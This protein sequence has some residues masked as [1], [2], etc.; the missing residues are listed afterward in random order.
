MAKNTK[1]TKKSPTTQGKPITD[2]FT[3]A[4]KPHPQP[5]KIRVSSSI[6]SQASSSEDIR[7]T[8]TSKTTGVLDNSKLAS[9]KYKPQIQSPRRHGRELLDGSESHSTKTSLSKT[10]FVS[11]SAISSR[12]LDSQ[13]HAGASAS[14][15]NKKALSDA[16]KMSDRRRN[17]RHSDSDTEMVN[18]TVHSTV[19]HSSI[20]QWANY[21]D[22]RAAQSK[23]SQESSAF[24][25]RGFFSGGLPYSDQP[26]R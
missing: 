20:S 8:G 2:F 6:P 13:A 24:A 7:P 11:S 22:N 23:K 14:Q 21:S 10:P 18:S 1:N 19:C 16:V 9:I 17:K 5:T 25:S 3:L 12:S 15:N 26:V 4:T